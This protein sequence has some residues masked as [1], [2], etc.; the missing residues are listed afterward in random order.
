MGTEKT[1][2]EEYPGTSS[3]AWGPARQ[4]ELLLVP[5]IRETAGIAEWALKRRSPKSIQVPH[6]QLE[7]LPRSPESE[8]AESV[9]RDDC[10]ELYDSVTL[11]MRLQGHL[12]HQQ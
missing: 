2:P 3:S 8:A 9:I 5:A 10:C 6:P 12:P 1:E 11:A 7:N 4:T